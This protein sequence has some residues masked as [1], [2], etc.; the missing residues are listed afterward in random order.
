MD[1]QQKADIEKRIKAFMEEQEQKRNGTFYKV[2]DENK[3]ITYDPNKNNHGETDNNI[4]QTI[5]NMIEIAGK[6]G[7][8]I[9]AKFNDAQFKIEPGM[10]SEQSYQAYYIALRERY[11]DANDPHFQINFDLYSPDIRQKVRGELYNIES[12]YITFPP[13]SQA[14][15][16]QDKDNNIVCTND[17][18]SLRWVWNPNKDILIQHNTQADCPYENL[19]YEGI[20]KFEPLT[21]KIEIKS[22]NLPTLIHKTENDVMI[23]NSLNTPSMQENIKSL[24]NGED[25]VIGPNSDVILSKK[26]GKLFLTN[27]GTDTAITDRTE[28]LIREQQ[29]EKE[30]VNSKIA[31]MRRNLAQKIDKVLGTNLTEKKLPKRLKK[32]EKTV[33]DKLLG[34]TRE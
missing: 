13:E 10:T 4:S 23:I 32:L 18:G 11:R 2:D 30:L 6:T 19:N 33:S 12:E 22:N 9:Q 8:T 1:E 29:L 21:Q 5:S 24:R 16:S 15:L 3:L 14:R 31:H 28:M 25:F 7:Y 27:Y 34:K 20:Q 26:N 17:D